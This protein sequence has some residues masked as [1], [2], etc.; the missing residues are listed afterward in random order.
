M[1]AILFDLDNTLIN[2]THSIRKARE[3]IVRF[4]FPDIS[5][6]ECN[7]I[8]DD[9][10]SWDPFGYASHF[11][12]FKRYVDTYHPRLIDV[13]EKVNFLVYNQGH[14]SVVADH[15]VSTLKQ[16][17]KHYKLGIVTNGNSYGQRLKMQ[18]AFGD[19]LSLFDVIVV[20]GDKGIH[21]PHPDIFLEA[22]HALDLP[23]EAILFVGDN[24]VNDIQGA[25]NVGMQ[26]TRINFLGLSKQTDVKEISSIVEL[27]P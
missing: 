12:L 27:I 11:L 1:K 16:L 23:C 26:A 19:A 13:K 3:I 25:L 18:Q 14:F 17:K 7:K 9:F 22:A 15:V 5:D 20:S 2:R 4:D 24:V 21:K 6:D 8:L 10:H